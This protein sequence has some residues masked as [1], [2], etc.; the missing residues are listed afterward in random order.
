VNDS[1]EFHIGE[2]FEF[3]ATTPPLD[4]G[5]AKAEAGVDAKAAAQLG[6]VAGPF[7]HSVKKAELEHSPAG[8]EKVFW[9]MSE[10]RFVQ[11]DD[12]TFIVVMQVPREVK[13]VKIAAAMQAYHSFNLW[14]ADL[15]AVMGFLRE[16]VAT[17]FSKGAPIRDTKVWD[18]TPK[19]QG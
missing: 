2:N 3:E 6:F 5:L 11:E 4:A 16:R 14:A 8:T 7:K 13:E 1:L 12:P 18:I 15:S 9:R 17:F 19:L 10:A